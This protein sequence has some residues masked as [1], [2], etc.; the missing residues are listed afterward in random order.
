MSPYSGTRLTEPPPSG[1]SPVAIASKG[2]VGN[3]TLF[4][5]VSSYK[6][7]VSSALFLFAKISRM[8]TPSLNREGKCHPTIYSEAR[9]QEF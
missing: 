3:D 9:E 8:F 1:A 6:T 2:A 4:L 7:H 5:H